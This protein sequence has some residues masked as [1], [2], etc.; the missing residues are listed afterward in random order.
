MLADRTSERGMQSELSVDNFK[1]LALLAAQQGQHDLAVDLLLVWQ[2]RRGDEQL[3][4][5]PTKTTQGTTWRQHVVGR[6]HSPNASTGGR[7]STAMPTSSN[8]RRN[9]AK[10]LLTEWKLEQPWPA[11]FV[12][13]CSA[14]YQDSDMPIDLGMIKEDVMLEHE[15]DN[16]LN[17]FRRERKVLVL[18]KNGVVD[19]W[20]NARIIRR[21]DDRTY[22]VKSWRIRER[23]PQEWVLAPSSS[24]IGA[25]L[26]EAA[27]QGEEELVEMLLSANASVYECDEDAN[28]PIYL[29]ARAGHANVCKLLYDADERTLQVRNRHRKNTQYANDVRTEAQP[30]LPRYVASSDVVPCSCWQGHSSHSQS[31]RS[32]SCS[33][34]DHGGRG[35]SPGRLRTL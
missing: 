35:P 25:V 19:A 28:L 30:S 7:H 12:A 31:C 18:V 10:V 8:A 27:K 16:I 20:E 32:C 9:L 6:R 26:R 22:D 34:S 3:V 1:K 13:L 15:R 14:K 24:G 5:S 2:E 33:Q 4:D 29:A 21:H 11:T 23:L 17:P